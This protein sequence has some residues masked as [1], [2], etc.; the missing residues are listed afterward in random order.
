MQ[1]S[2]M[3]VNQNDRFYELVIILKLSLHGP[4]T[5]SSYSRLDY[6]EKENPGDK[7]LP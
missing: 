4:G 3:R 1:Q 5:H 7:R 6:L 2:L